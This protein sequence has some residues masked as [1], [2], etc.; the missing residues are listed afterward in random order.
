MK[1]CTSKF[2]ERG[3]R[4]RSWLRHCATSRKVAGSI[5]SAF[6]GIFHW[7]NSSGRTMALGLTQPLK[8]LSTRIISW[9]K[10]GLCIG[11][12]TLPPSSVKLSWH[13]GA[14]TSWNPRSL[15][16]PVM[17]LLYLPSLI[18][19][20]FLKT[21]AMWHRPVNVVWQKLQLRDRFSIPGKG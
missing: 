14:S 15:S 12:T 10:G 9:C 20:I 4:W 13:L 6:I 17:G 18:P 8:V 19:L 11:L 7:H 2:L 1:L 5:T 3:T 16:R 21:C